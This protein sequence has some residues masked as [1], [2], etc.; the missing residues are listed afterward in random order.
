MAY[1]GGYDDLSDASDSEDPWAAESKRE[2]KVDDENQDRIQDLLDEQF[3]PLKE[4][5]VVF[6]DAQMPDL[7]VADVFGAVEE[8][9]R[10]KIVQSK[11]DMVGGRGGATQ[12]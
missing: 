2:Q 1:R 7:L 8:H 3:E 12:C 10:R 5:C 4:A 9:V 11:D 6:I